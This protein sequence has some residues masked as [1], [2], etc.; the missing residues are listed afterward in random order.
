MCVLTYGLLLSLINCTELPLPPS[1]VSLSSHEVSL[2]I[3]FSTTSP[4]ADKPPSPTKECCSKF[5][6]QKPTLGCQKAKNDD[7]EE[8]YEINFRVSGFRKHVLKRVKKSF[9]KSENKFTFRGK[10]VL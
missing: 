10:N 8:I 9:C 4:P 6:E 5:Q 3:L 2:A 1:S 7:F